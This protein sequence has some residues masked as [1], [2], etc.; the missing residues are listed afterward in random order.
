[1]GMLGIRIVWDYGCIFLFHF[2]QK[3]V[4]DSRLALDSLPL[5]QSPDISSVPDLCHFYTD[6]NPR[7][8]NSD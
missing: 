3:K 7:I 4:P 1:M 8:R 5:C 2:Q 6:P